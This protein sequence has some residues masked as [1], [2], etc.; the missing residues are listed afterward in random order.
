MPTTSNTAQDRLAALL[1][2]LPLLLDGDTCHGEGP[3]VV[4]V[5][6]SVLV[7]T[8]DSVEGNSVDI[9]F[10][11]GVD[12]V[13]AGCL[14]CVVTKVVGML[15]VGMSVIGWLVIGTLVV[16]FIVSVVKF[17]SVVLV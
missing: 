11:V 10:V 15:V 16:A 6:G 3:I 13:L 4:P 14:G 12:S 17:F 2:S 7:T 8:A 1:V 9:R 5:L